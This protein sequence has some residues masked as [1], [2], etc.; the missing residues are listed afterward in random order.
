MSG[1]SLSS[2]V[3][4]GAL[5]RSERS[6]APSDTKAAG[7]VVRTSSVARAGAVGTRK[8][9]SM[10]SLAPAATQASPPAH[11]MFSPVVDVW[12]RSVSG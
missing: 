2:S 12:D 7:N 1:V 11:V 9:I 4:F 8:R 3:P 6:T 5:Y 10:A